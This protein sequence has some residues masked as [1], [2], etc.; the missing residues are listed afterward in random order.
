MSKD[1]DMITLDTHILIWY[2]EGI[3]LMD[4]SVK[5]IDEVRAKGNL[6]IS[7]MTV[8]EIALLCNKGRITLS[9]PLSSWLDK[10]I[11]MDGLSVIDLSLD[12]LIASCSL[13]NYQYRDPADRM[14]IA[15]AQSIDSYL[16]THDN[17]IL[18][19]AKGG[20]LKTL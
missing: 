12:I 7:A 2:V 4:D 15:S 20:Y 13:F 5:L 11:S 10:I 16:M 14:I 8:W 3:N 18:E 17:K 6:Y 19:Y 1:I 9:L